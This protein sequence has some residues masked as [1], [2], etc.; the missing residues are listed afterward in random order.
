MP[1]LVLEKALATSMVAVKKWAGPGA[2]IT[3]NLQ[4]GGRRVNAAN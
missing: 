4:K 1:C 2:V 3:T